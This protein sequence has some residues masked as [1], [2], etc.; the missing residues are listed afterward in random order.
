MF[1]EL[2]FLAGD[3]PYSFPSSCNDYRCPISKTTLNCVVR[4]LDLNGRD[5][6][7]HDFRHTASTLLHEQGYSSDWVEKCLA[8]KIGGVRSVYNRAQ[9]LNQRREMLQSW[10]DFVDAQIEE[11]ERWLSG[12]LRRLM[13]PNKKND[14]LS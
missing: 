8:H 1:E 3:S 4:T 6:V 12:N 11:G 9:Y 2:K 5:F 14:S 10:A 7:I 13:R